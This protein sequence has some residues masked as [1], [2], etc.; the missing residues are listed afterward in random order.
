MKII[1]TNLNK[2]KPWLVY[3]LAGIFLFFGIA[4]HA[5]NFWELPALQMLLIFALFAPMLAALF[6]FMAHRLSPHLA[7]I[8][9]SH[10][11]LLC[12]MAAA[13]SFFIS[14]RI[15]RVPEVFQTVTVA[16]LNGQVGLLEVKGNFQVIPLYKAAIESNW[17]EKDGTYFATPDS[18]ALSVSFKAPANKPI[19]ILFLSSP[20]GGAAEVTLNR[21]SARQVELINDSNGQ[22]TTRLVSDYRNLPGQLFFA[23]LIVADIVTFELLALGL[24]LLQEIGQQAQPA[25]AQD[26]KK[27]TWMRTDMVILLGVGLILHVINMLAVPLT[28][29]PDSPAYLRGAVHLVENGNLQGVSSNYG[30]GSTLLF[31][32]MLWLFG[33]SPWGIKILLHLIALACIP[34]FYRLGWQVSKRR[35]IALISGL[36]IAN[37]PDI[38]FYTNYPMTEIPN[39]FFVL[40]FCTLLISAIEK[41]RLPW[42]ISMM[43]A[44]SFASMLRSENVALIGI[45]ALALLLSGFW[46]WYSGN[47]AEVRRTA[48]HVGISILLACMPVLWWSYHN[49]KYHGFFGMSDYMG[50]VL[51]DGWVYYGDASIGSFSAQNS[52]AV[53]EIKKVAEQYPP[54]ITDKKGVATSRQIFN[55]FMEA[56]YE[57]NQT[58]SVIKTAALD[59][60][61]QNPKKTIELLFF[62]YNKGL[63]PEFPPKITYPLPGEPQRYGGSEFFDLDL[64]VIPALIHIQRAAHQAA[65]TWYS[66]LYPGWILVCIAALISS[67]VRKPMTTWTMLIVTIAYKIFMP[68]TISVSFWRYTLSG[69]LP[70]QIIALSWLVLVISGAFVVFKTEGRSKEEL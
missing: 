14:W 17:Q 58:I 49:L 20:Q 3:A 36:V 63:Q 18:K 29:N 16:P 48:F 38:F 24:L 44:A 21:Q 69:F 15:H 9:K 57:S 11:L 50:Q 55:S 61:Q 66:L 56:G 33:K 47:L 46:R 12:L 39:I 10:L 1:N 30:V 5:L 6:A 60:I 54:R 42:M 40:L 34:L 62:K 70:V 67:S 32:P 51:Y 35:S 25:L 22:V 19:T 28:L 8:P 37:S 27:Q 4:H 53:Q 68:L 2:L 59:S 52:A 64:L 13:I 31:A 41:M 7:R 26:K 23:L 65:D 43:L 45:G